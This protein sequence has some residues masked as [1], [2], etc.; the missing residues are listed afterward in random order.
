MIVHTQRRLLD[1]LFGAQLTVIVGNADADAISHALSGEAVDPIGLELVSFQ[2]AAGNGAAALRSIGSPEEAE[3]A[4]PSPPTAPCLPVALSEQGRAELELFLSWWTEH[5]PGL[6]P[7]ILSS[8][9]PEEPL[10]NTRDARRA[11]IYQQILQALIRENTEA[12]QRQAEVSEQL[13]ELRLEYEQ[14]RNAMASLQTELHGIQQ[15]TF[16]IS[17]LSPPR[18]ET[19]GPDAREPFEVRQPLTVPAAGLAGFD[20]YLPRQAAS[21]LGQGHL[22]ISLHSEARKTEL[23]RWRLPYESLGTGWVGCVFESAMTSP[24]HHLFVRV[25]WET[26][27]GPPPRLALSSL[28]PFQELSAS[29][30]GQSIGSAL[31]L[32][33]WS[34]IPGSRIRNRHG[35]WSSASSN[36]T[37]P[38]TFEYLLAKEDIARIRPLTRTPRNYCHQLED[39]PGFR[40]HPI[41]NMIASAVLP[42]GCIVGTSQ[43]VAMVQIRSELAQHPVEYAM[44]LSEAEEPCA[45]VLDDPNQRLIACSG[46]QLV[47]PD[48]KPVAVTLTLD[49]PLSRPAHLCFATRLTNGHPDA[50]EWADWLEVRPRITV[51]SWPMGEGSG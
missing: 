14:A 40:L 45:S 26:V 47:Q 46:W 21:A 20:L 37:V 34:T 25:T 4:M 12:N 11:A 49:E 10:D 8:F 48:S 9:G 39:V 38:N 7:E 18:N 15:S 33:V 16:R 17:H 50:H 23:G 5:G 22:L 43:L 41:E 35:S 29:A 28:G 44:Y 27:K 32:L 24:V 19:V 51:N 31:A 13:Y 36:D 6:P 1:K 3:A 30:N 42:N 2:P